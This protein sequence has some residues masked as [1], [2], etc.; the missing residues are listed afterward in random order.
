MVCRLNAVSQ[1]KTDDLTRPC[2]R[3]EIGNKSLDHN[4]HQNRKICILS[5]NL[6]HRVRK[7]SSGTALPSITR[8]DPA[9]FG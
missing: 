8:F 3:F 1:A 5:D 9:L 7:R 2:H 6:V 4:G